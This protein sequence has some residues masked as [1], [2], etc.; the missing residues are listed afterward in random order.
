MKNTHKYISNS[1]LAIV[2]IGVFS[3]S[4]FSRAQPV[5]EASTSPVRRGEA[6]DKVSIMFNVYQGTEYLDEILDILDKV[7]AKTTFFVGGTWAEKNPSALK[8]IAQKGHELGNH[9]YFHRD[10]SKLSSKENAREISACHMLVKR[11]TGVVMDLF[12]P[13]SGAYSS[14]TLDIAKE[15]GYN[16]IMW[17]KDTIDWRDKDVSVLVRRATKGIKGGDLILMH[18]TEQSVKALDEIVADIYAQGLSIA[19]VSEII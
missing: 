19:P 9:G 1:I 14:N 2:I 18:P 12:A 10:H 3:F 15:M 8:K 17:S 13:P 5:S 6:S 11:L 16:T 4:V 7:G